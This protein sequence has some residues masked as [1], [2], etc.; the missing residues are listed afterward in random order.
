MQTFKKLHRQFQQYQQKQN[1]PPQ[2]KGL[3]D[4]IRYIMNLKGKQL[5]PLMLLMAYLLYEE[6]PSPAL[7]VAYAIELFH[8][9]TLLHDDIMDEAALRRGSPTVHHIYGTN[10]AILSGD[11]MM[12]YV[13]KYISQAVPKKLLPHILE[14]FNEVAIGVCEG[15]QMDMDF[16]NRIDVSL[17]EYLQMIELKTAV[18]IAGTLKMGALLGGASDKDAT[19]L[20]HFGKNIGIAF[21][22]QDDYLD[23]F[24]DQ[25]TFGKKIGGD[26][27]QNK[28]TYLYLK[29]RQVA[30]KAQNDLLD[31]YYHSKDQEEEEKIKM[32]TSLF[33]ELKVQKSAT[34]L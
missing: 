23:T 27:I 10:T 14:V 7:P 4:P 31:H 6:E 12:I 28:K 1:F 29:A 18:L 9:F 32:V 30:D 26:I 21:Q 25:K 33:K 16:E 3:Y 11:V 34:L 2:P 17:A 24:G 15:Q 5:R 19:H 8:S 13:Y 22:I 20:Y